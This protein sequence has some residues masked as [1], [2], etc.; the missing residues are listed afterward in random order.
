MQKIEQLYR[1]DYAGEHVNVVG[2]YS[3]A[4]WHYDKEF[5]SNPFDYV[6]ISNTAMVTGNGITRE[7]VNLKLV[8]PF[9]NSSS[10]GER[11]PWWPTGCMRRFNTYGCNALYR[12]FRPDFLV[13]TGPDMVKEL[14]ESGYCDDNVVYA[15]KQMVAEHPGKFLLV[16][17]DPQWNS[18]SIA[19]YM[20]AFDGH[21]K[22]FM[23][24][25]DGVDSDDSSYNIYAG[26][27]A[28]LERSDVALEHYWEMSMLQVF[29]AYPD[30]EFIRVAP[31]DCFRVPEQWKY[32][33]NYRTTSFRQFV[34][35][36]DIGH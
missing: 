8:M 6:P 31:T 10:F 2:R 22:V 5:I 13:A 14:V 27:N 33:L 15:S 17:Q 4:R 26:T 30:V 18:G 1:K 16:P 19:T 29:N 35:E 3:G 11:G 24:G 28:Y 34:L 7:Q 32:C 20:A 23:I 12:D 9:R 36:A 25:F 21:K